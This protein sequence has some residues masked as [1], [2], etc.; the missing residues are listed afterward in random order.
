MRR[1]LGVSLTALLIAAPLALVASQASSSTTATPPS[2]L[3]PNNATTKIARFHFC[4][5]NGIT[6]AEPYQVWDEFK[7]YDS[8]I[9]RGARIAPYIGHDEPATLFY[10]N[11]P[12][13]GNNVTY[14]MVLPKDPPTR[15]KQDGSGGTYGFQ[16]HPTFWLGMVVCDLTDRPTRTERR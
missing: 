4:G 1:A 11:R 15:P 13:S 12:G 16:L 9:K 8:A 3:L 6:C 7:G 10:S 14:Q 5:N 2:H